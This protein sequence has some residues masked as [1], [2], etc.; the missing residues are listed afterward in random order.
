MVA[1]FYFGLSLGPVDLIGI[2]MNKAE[3]DSRVLVFVQCL[4]AWKEF[5]PLVF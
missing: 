4:A 5:N 3:H 2:G 1:V